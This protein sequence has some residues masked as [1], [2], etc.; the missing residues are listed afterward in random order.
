M[1]PGEGGCFSGEALQ[2][3]LEQEFGWEQGPGWGEEEILVK[4]SKVRSSRGCRPQRPGGRQEVVG[5]C[6]REAGLG[7]VRS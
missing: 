4:V 7:T 1:A 6:E 5:R 2:L 3:V